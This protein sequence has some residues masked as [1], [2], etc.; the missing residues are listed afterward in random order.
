MDIQVLGSISLMNAINITNIYTTHY[1]NTCQLDN[2]L[3]NSDRRLF[4]S[5]STCQPNLIYSCMTLSLDMD[6]CQNSYEYTTCDYMNLIGC[7]QNP[8]NCKFNKYIW[9]S[10]CETGDVCEKISS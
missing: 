3:I 4:E 2:W 10:M 5:I 7:H 6:R 8:K 1:P 9:G